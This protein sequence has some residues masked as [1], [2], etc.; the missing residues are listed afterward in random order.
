[1]TDTQQS[2]ATLRRTSTSCHG[3]CQFSIGKQLPNKHGF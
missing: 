1:M 2:W 3:N